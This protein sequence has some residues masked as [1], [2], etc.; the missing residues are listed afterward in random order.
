MVLELS[1]E[2]VEVVLEWFLVEVGVV[3]LASCM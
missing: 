3:E 2:E 1:E